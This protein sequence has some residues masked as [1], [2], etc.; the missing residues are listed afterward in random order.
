MTYTDKQVILNSLHSSNKVV[1]DYQ[2][3]WNTVYL[4]VNTTSSSKHDLSNLNRNCESVCLVCIYAVSILGFENCQSFFSHNC[5]CTY[6]VAQ[7]AAHR[8]ARRNAMRGVHQFDRHN[9]CQ[10]LKTAA[11]HHIQT[12]V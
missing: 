10:T 9:T 7:C 11:E 1:V 8:N 3:N 2:D 12:T 5:P 6:G 4:Y